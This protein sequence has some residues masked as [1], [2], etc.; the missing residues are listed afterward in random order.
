M[1]RDPMMGAADPLNDFS[2]TLGYKPL[3]EGDALMEGSAFRNLPDEAAGFEGA[4]RDF[5]QPMFDA[6]DGMLYQENLL[7]PNNYVG[8]S[9]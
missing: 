5:E 4:L 2:M 1:V 9:P 8:I 6:A 7:E 3:V